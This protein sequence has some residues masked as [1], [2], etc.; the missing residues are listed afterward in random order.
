M[1][2]ETTDKIMD[3]ASK[4]FGAAG[5]ATAKIVAVGKEKVD[6]ASL[7]RR[8]AKRQR[9]LGILVYTQYKSGEK[10]EYLVERYIR[11]IDH[12]HLMLAEMNAPHD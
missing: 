5:E 4:M 11:E 8:L 7:Q 6:I 2:N 3:V 10:D 1:M 9:Q 12:I